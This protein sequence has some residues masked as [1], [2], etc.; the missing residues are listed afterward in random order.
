M[1][2]STHGGKVF[3]RSRENHA[4]APGWVILTVVCAVQFLT[5][6]MMSSV[7]VA[8]PAIGEE[9]AASGVQL[10]LVET[11]FILAV[12]LF[13]L[14]SGRLGDLYGHKRVFLLGTVLFIGATLAASLAGGIDLFLLWRFF[15]GGGAAMITGTSLAILSSVFSPEK[16]AKAMG[17]VVACIY[18]GVSAGP[19]V[20]GLLVT[21]LGWRW[22]FYAAFALG[23]GAL[24]LTVWKMRGEWADSAGG[25]FDVVGSLFYMGALFCLI[26]GVVNQSSGGRFQVM[27][28]LGMGGLLMFVL[29][30]SKIEEPLVD[31]RL[32]LSS[33]VFAFSNLATLINYAAS[34]GATFFFSLYL[35]VVKGL[36]PQAAGLILVSQPLLQAV[37][38]PLSGVLATRVP[39]AKLATFGMAICVAGLALA[40]TVHRSTG[41]GTIGAI[42]AVMGVGFA[43]FSTPNM[44][45]VMGSVAPRHYGLAS[46]LVSTMRTLGM[47]VSMTVATVVVSSYMGQRAING[48]TS[49]LF[50]FAMHDAFLIF[51]GLSVVGIF[52]SMV[53]LNGSAAHG[54][55]P[56]VR[57][58]EHR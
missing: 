25:R 44:L 26:V 27:A 53:R 21:Q 46:S 40:A 39:S 12:S 5:P 18:L 17:L 57:E 23:C 32:I 20:G 6:F 28:A 58:I 37:L 24:L 30:E 2:R 38:S 49:E 34:F 8:L 15:Q 42:L 9:Y 43:L 3:G 22:I 55:P 36:S 16:R 1:E 14:P 11:V 52:L 48:A 29:Y 33:R 19:L 4:G 54:V 7:G 41:Y 56:G 50:L 31:V 51:S 45:T 13:L 47:L 10:G 35:Q